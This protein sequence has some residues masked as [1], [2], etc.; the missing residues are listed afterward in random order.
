MG[1]LADHAV[2]EG[3][4]LGVLGATDEGRALYETLDWKVYAPLAACIYRP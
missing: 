2:T 4:T 3:A 1:T